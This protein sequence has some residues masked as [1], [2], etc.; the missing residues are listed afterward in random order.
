MLHPCV[1]ARLNNGTQEHL[2]ASICEL[3][4]KSLILAFD[5]YGLPR[6]RGGLELS[7]SS[8]SEPPPCCVGRYLQE[9]KLEMLGLRILE[10][11]ATL[12]EV[13]LSIKGHYIREN[14]EVVITRPEVLQR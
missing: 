2:C 9:V 10:T 1:H 14:D 3:P 12:Q 6:W 11:V 7:T 8:T 5:C 13:T 4:L